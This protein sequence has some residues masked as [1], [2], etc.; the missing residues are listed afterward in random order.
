MI[1]QPFLWYLIIT[2][3]GLLT[4]PLGY[5]LL[6]ALA[7]RGYALSRSMGWLLWGYIFWLLT[8]LGILRNNL[9]GLLFALALL[10]GLSVWASR[11]IT[12]DEMLD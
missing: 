1:L 7:D 8:S 11:K 12:M 4:F 3:L 6:P 5:R 10:V 2:L 9:G